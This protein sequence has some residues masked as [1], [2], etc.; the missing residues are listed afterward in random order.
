MPVLMS[1]LFWRMTNH[2]LFKVNVETYTSGLQ[3]SKL[4]LVNAQGYAEGTG[5]M[6]TFPRFLAYAGV[7]SIFLHHSLDCMKY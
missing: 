6:A 7:T 4:V 2:R 5:K 3:V 1:D